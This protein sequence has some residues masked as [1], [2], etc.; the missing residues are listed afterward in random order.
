MLT[1]KVWKDDSKFL[2]N[3]EVEFNHKAATQG[4]TSCHTGSTSEG[5]VQG[6][7]LAAS[8]EVKPATFRTEGTEHH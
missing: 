1:S 8:G 5:L 2:Q 3:T 6:F 4:A 7:Y